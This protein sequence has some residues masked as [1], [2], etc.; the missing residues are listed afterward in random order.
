MLYFSKLCVVLTK[1]PNLHVVLS[2]YAIVHTRIPKLKKFSLHPGRV[3]KPKA[4]ITQQQCHLQSLHKQAIQMHSQ[5]QLVNYNTSQDLL[6]S[7]THSNFQ[8]N[9]E[10]VLLY[11]SA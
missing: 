1:F 7:L 8:D 6:E 4:G 2:N 3:R 11:K 5:K 9:T 10:N